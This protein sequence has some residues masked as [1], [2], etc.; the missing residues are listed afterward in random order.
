[1]PIFIKELFN[2][3]YFL[4]GFAFVFAFAIT[5]I[6]IPAVIKVAELK[7]LFDEPDETRKKHVHKTPTLGGVAI[8]AGLII[9]FSLLKDFKSLI[10]VKYLVPALIIIFFAGIKDDILVLTPLKKLLAQFMC[11]FLIAFLGNIKINSFYGMFG[12]QEMPAWFAI[13]FTILAIVTIINCYN[14]ID[15][16]DGLAGSLGL[17][18]AVV[19]G[20]WFALTAH[21]SLAFLSF[22]LAGSLGGFLFFNWQPAKIFMGD[23]GA[24]LVGFVLSVL[25][26]HFIELNKAL[27]I[28]PEYWIHASPSVA[29]GIMAI[30]VFDLVRV[31]AMRILKR[32]SPFHPDRS[33]LHHLFID[34]GW[35]HRQL[36]TTMFLWNLAVILIC[37]ALRD[38]K[39]SVLLLLLIVLVFVP[40]VILLKL[41]NHKIVKL[42]QTKLATVK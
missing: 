17:L 20:I 34:L 2:N 39:S 9:S 33:H 8:F 11:A 13:T 27:T 1:M 22:S 40:S 16:A 3:Y 19:F 12:L 37:F 5:A 15:G 41:R 28:E 26:I 24:M 14:L 6:A 23:T 10:D 31:F 21:W 18:S 30:P 32:K 35:T 4:T 7:H 42:D 25:A 38:A 29:I 36:A